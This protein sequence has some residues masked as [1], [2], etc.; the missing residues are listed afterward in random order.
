MIFRESL[1]KGKLPDDWKKAAVAPIFKSGNKK[2]PSNYRP[3][4]LTSVVC[5]LCEKIIRDK[6]MSYLLNM[7]LLSDNQ[8][9]FRPK[10]SCNIQ[11]LEILDRWAE[12]VDEG[13][14]IDV[15]YLDFS[16]AFDSVAHDR[17]LFKLNC[18][19]VHG[20]TLNWIE[21]F[22][23]AR[24]QCVRIGP[25]TS[26]WSKVISGVPQ[27]SVLGPVLFLC[28]I[29]DLPD[30]VN[31]IV[32]IFADDTKIYS[33]VNTTTQCDEL[34]QDLDNLCDWSSKWKLSFNAKKCK[35]MHIGSTNERHRYSMLDKDGNFI[36]L[37]SAQS[38]KDLGVTFNEN[39]H[40]GEHIS[41]IT[42]K[43]QRVLG[44][45]HRSF[46]YMETEMLLPLYKSLVRPILEYGSNVWS[47]YLKKDIKK[48]EDVQRRATRLVPACS[49]LPYEERLKF[50]GLPTLE[51]RRDR[52]DMITLYKS[53]YGLDDL[54]WSNI[55]NLAQGDLRGHHLKFI[56]K[57]VSS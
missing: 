30:V 1:I 52:S 29:N 26:N 40:F 19:G 28:F 9:G 47:P 49:T 22:L 46:E 11:L 27:G 48:I 12:S 35:V 5:K 13:S 55:F 38:E 50:L 57:K 41:N 18:L 7:N 17:L 33:N 39:L 32:K 42:S 21:N 43:A 53:I 24:S 16:K 54:K 36:H 3:V 37:D 44:L 10:R 20:V 34:Q 51:Y 23:T 31:G 15:I 25:A 6:L 8:Y 14:P 45:I 4:S 56:K 2:E